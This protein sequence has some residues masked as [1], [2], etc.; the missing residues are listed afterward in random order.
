MT[1]ALRSGALREDLRRNLAHKT[2]RRA[3]A[4]KKP[5]GWS[6]PGR[7]RSKLGRAAAPESDRGWP[8]TD[9]RTGH[10]TGVRTGRLCRLVTLGCKVNQYETQYVKEALEAHGWHEAVDGEAAQLCVVNTCT[11]TAEGDA[12]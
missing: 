8:M 1:A 6:A 12:K 9:D 11:V 4:A 7:I 2:R 5:H 3:A 10:A